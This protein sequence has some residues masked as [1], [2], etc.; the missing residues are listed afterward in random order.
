[1]ALAKVKRMSFKM[2]GRGRVR[3]GVYEGTLA[4]YVN[5]TGIAMSKTTFAPLDNLLFVGITFKDATGLYTVDWNRATGYAKVYT[6]ATGVEV[7]NDALD[8]VTAT[9]FYLGF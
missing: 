2:P 4:G 6:A 7:A 3:F 8:A 9:V 1:M 5:G